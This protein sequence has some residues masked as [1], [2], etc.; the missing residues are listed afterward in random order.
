MNYEK[1]GMAFKIERNQ[2][3][4]NASFER[5]K[6][7]IGQLKPKSQQTYD[8]AVRLSEIWVNWKYLGC[9]YPEKVM[10]EVREVLDESVNKK[11]INIKIKPK[12]KVI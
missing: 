10:K 4:T 3:E 1:S 11:K 5:R 12:V 2:D 8:E 9:Q 6:W 7:F